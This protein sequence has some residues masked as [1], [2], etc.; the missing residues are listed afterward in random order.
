HNRDVV[1]N[2][3]IV[4]MR[5]GRQEE[6]RSSVAEA[7]T[8]APDDEGLNAQMGVVLLQMNRPAEA[9]EPLRRALKIDLHDT[10]ARINLAVALNHCGRWAEV[11]SHCDEWLA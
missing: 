4:L 9:V 11:I 1:I 10:G 7:L 2:R 8:S 5:L 6:A 3:S